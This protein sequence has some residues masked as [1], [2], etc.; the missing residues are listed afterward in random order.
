MNLDLWAIMGTK[1]S[2]NLLSDPW[3]DGRCGLSLELVLRSRLCDLGTF[4]MS[5]RDI[6][7]GTPLTTSVGKPLPFSPSPFLVLLFRR[8]CNQNTKITNPRI[9]AS[10]TNVPTSAYLHFMLH[11]GPLPGSL[12]P[13]LPEALPTVGASLCGLVPGRFFGFDGI[14]GVSDFL[15]PDLGF[16]GFD[17]DFGA[18]VS[19][20][21]G[22]GSDSDLD[23][24]LASGLDS[25]LGAGLCTGLGAGTG[26]GAGDLCMV[27]PFGGIVFG[28]GAG[29]GAR[30]GPDLDPAGDNLLELEGFPDAGLD[31][32]DDELPE[33]PRPP[34]LELEPPPPLRFPKVTGSAFTKDRI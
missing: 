4:N 14:P 23:P 13:P 31:E 33:G 28:D 29:T 21:F 9:I 6:V 1:E 7:N 20:G 30:F 17:P 24:D 3:S 12:C 22:L 2:R 8:L 15:P 27:G 11:E 16:S 10:P 5:S 26:R 25:D 32:P 19:A 18:V 34:A